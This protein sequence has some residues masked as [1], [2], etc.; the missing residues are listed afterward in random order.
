V[1]VVLRFSHRHLSLFRKYL[2][3]CNPTC[4]GICQDQWQGLPDLAQQALNATNGVANQASELETAATIAE[5]QMG[6]PDA[7]FQS[8]VDA[9][10]SSLPACLPYIDIIATYVSKLGGGS[11]C[12]MVF[13][14][15][16]FSKEYGESRVLGSEFLG[17]V[18]NATFQC[19][20]T[21]FPHLRTALIAANLISP[22]VIDGIARLLVRSDVEGLK[23]KENV[24]KILDI[25]GALGHAWEIV[26]AHE[27]AGHLPTSH[28]VFG[29]FS[30]R[31]VLHQLQKSKLGAEGRTFKS[32]A[33]IKT[34]FV[35]DL[36]KRLPQD[37][38]TNCV[39]DAP[40]AELHQPDQAKPDTST[41]IKFDD[42]SDPKWIAKK[43]GY[44]LNRFYK[45]NA[46]ADEERKLYQL[47]E[48]RQD[49]CIFT[50]HNKFGESNVLDVNYEDMGRRM[51]KYQGSLPKLI[52][53]D[54]ASRFA[55]SPA[56]TRDLCKAELFSALCAVA[57]SHAVGKALLT[58][59]ANPQ[60][61]RV[62]KNVKK[63]ALV[64]V[65]LTELSRISSALTSTSGVVGSV[66]GEKFAIEAPHKAKI[67]PE[68]L[69]GP[70]DVEL[71]GD[72][73]N[74]VVA[75]WWV[76]A[77][78]DSSAANMVT[79][80]KK[81]GNATVACLTNNRALKAWDV[82][83]FHKAKRPF[84]PSASLTADLNANATK[85]GRRK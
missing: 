42:V 55:G 72:G 34:L 23:R 17:A 50:Q 60:E 47:T 62:S 6:S 45:D 66:K 63:N 39:W 37:V 38:P 30:T 85:I 21:L 24:Q 58:F 73:K 9:A 56:Q 18:V 43:H 44:E 67:T 83:R 54:V 57:E 22:K 7:S 46:D 15:D 11:T 41:E 36:K 64:L 75:H 70:D 79:V 12:P 59:C 40:V 20:S 69:D 68:Q 52:T 80:M 27:A 16:T 53:F 65:P 3:S 49:G 82:L 48:M 26:K 35:T 74:F 78:P 25:E 51:S 1:R 10:A 77:T 29:R 31:I 8:C 19:N 32:Q 84:E 76:S 81:H 2:C 14:L 33:E 71:E 28:I 13:F 4:I 61:L 5:Y